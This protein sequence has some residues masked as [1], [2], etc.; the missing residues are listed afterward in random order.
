M[1]EIRGRSHLYTIDHGFDNRLL[2]HAALHGTDARVPASVASQRR[3]LSAEKT[4]D[5]Y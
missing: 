2:V 1:K 4:H 3:V 5:L